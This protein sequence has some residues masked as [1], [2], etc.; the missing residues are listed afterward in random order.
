MAAESMEES[1]P[2]KAPWGDTC[3]ALLRYRGPVP[4]TPPAQRDQQR[5]HSAPRTGRLHVQ[6]PRHPR[7]LDKPPSSPPR[8]SPAPAAK[9]PAYAPAP[10]PRSSPDP[11]Q[12]YPVPTPV[13]PSPSPLPFV[14]AAARSAAPQTI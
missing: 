8:S 14:A 5:V 1:P 13:K 10:C 12:S 4:F 9:S 11:S 2:A 3:V 7:D 6:P